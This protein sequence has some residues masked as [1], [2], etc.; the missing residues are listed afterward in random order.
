[1]KVIGVNFSSRKNGNCFKCADYCLERF[2]ETGHEV[3]IVNFFDYHISPCGLCGYQCFQTGSC[4]KQDEART[5]FE[6][7]AAADLILHAVPTFRGHLASSFFIL[8]ERAQGIF[9]KEL[10]YEADYLQKL[11]LIVIG[12]L[13]SGAD[14]ALHEAFYDFTNRDFYPESILL[15]SREY[16]RRSISGDL[17]EETLVRNRLD[18]YVHR[19]MKRCTANL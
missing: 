2:K 7:L 10:S 6:K 17:I 18:Q 11:H 14:M 3:E 19:I 1:M 5:L 4:I 8:S 15:S 13:S 12:N 9:K 16:D